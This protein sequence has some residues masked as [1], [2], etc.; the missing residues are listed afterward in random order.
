MSD[1]ETD[2]LIIGTG[3]AGGSMAA[4]L[5]SYS[6]EN[7]VINRTGGSPTRPNTLLL[8]ITNQRTMETLRSSRQTAWHGETHSGTMK[9]CVV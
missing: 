8:H 4:L 5:S 1:I 7:M 9:R 2:V 6:V 3:P